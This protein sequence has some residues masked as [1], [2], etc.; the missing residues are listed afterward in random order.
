[1][2]N[3][4]WLKAPDFTRAPRAGW[5][6]AVLDNEV[7]MEKYAREGDTL[8]FP[9]CEKMTSAAL[10]RCHCF[11]EHMEYRWMR[12]GS[13]GR[14]LEKVL[15]AEEETEMAPDLL[16]MDRMILSEKYMP[17]EQG[18]WAIRVM[19]RYRYTASNTLTLENYRFAGVERA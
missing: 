11:D 19:N 3:R 8:R 18:L 12:I 17:P 6:L 15:T 4:V 10:R 1:M 2:N 16:F 14:S 7:L 5:I 13:R 9:G